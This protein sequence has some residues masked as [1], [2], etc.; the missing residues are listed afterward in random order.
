MQPPYKTPPHKGREK[1]GGGVVNIDVVEVALI[2]HL[3]P[4]SNH[5]SL[6]YIRYNWND[7]LYVIDKLHLVYQSGWLGHTISKVG[8][9]C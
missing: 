2:I 1:L 5:S 9:T 6:L 3:V 4:S 8:N 7:C